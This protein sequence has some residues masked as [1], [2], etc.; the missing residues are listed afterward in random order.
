MD[1]PV[2]EVPKLCE[3]LT[4]KRDGCRTCV[5]ILGSGLNLQAVRMEGRREDDWAGLLTRIARELDISPDEI[6]RL[7]RPQ[8]FRW[9]SMLR[10]WARV[11]RI[12]P[13]QAEAQLQKLTCEYLRSLEA[14]ASAL[15]LYRDFSNAQFADIVSLN[16]DRRLAL[17]FREPRFKR[18]PAHCPQGTYG[19]TLYRHDLLEHADGTQTRIWY[20]HGDTRKAAT[21]KLGV[22]K[23]GFYIGTIAEVQSGAPADFADWRF[24]RSWMQWEEL[25]NDQREDQQAPMWI[26]PFLNAAIVFI[27]CGLS[28]DEW[29][30]WS[31]LQDRARIR[32]RNRAPAYFVT[33]SAI[34]AEQ[35]SAFAEYGIEI[36]SYPSFDRMWDDIRMAIA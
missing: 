11:K 35:S 26:D 30:L 20:P 14:T 25:R 10:L 18:G 12:E 2:A 33:G 1:G 24:K 23:Y 32:S 8:L 31:T 22:R 3:V 27:G 19:E 28:A 4:A 17:S 6:D 16:F 36:A 29:P 15:S 21:L 5:P 7:P 13:Y 9:E 34:S